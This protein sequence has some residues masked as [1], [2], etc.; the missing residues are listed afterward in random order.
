MRIQVITQQK[1]CRGLG[2]GED[3]EWGSEGGLGQ[4]GLSVRGPDVLLQPCLAQSLTDV[5]RAGEDRASLL[6]LCPLSF[7]RR[8]ADL[9]RVTQSIIIPT[10]GY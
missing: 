1:G 3:G 4:T 10:Q 2:G 8:F 5:T 7:P 9:F 6:E